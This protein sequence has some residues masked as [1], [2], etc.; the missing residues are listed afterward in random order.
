D[1]GKRVPQGSRNSY[2]RAAY[3]SFIRARRW[4]YAVERD[5][6][7]GGNR[8]VRAARVGDAERKAV[9]V[10]VVRNRVGAD[11]REVIVTA[12]DADLYL[13][14]QSVTAIAGAEADRLDAIDAR[15]HGRGSRR[16]AAGA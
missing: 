6:S 15:C 8:G 16:A 13:V 9:Q 12:V 14:A 11:R 10:T 5:R 3:G 1:R 7:A 4:V 2:T